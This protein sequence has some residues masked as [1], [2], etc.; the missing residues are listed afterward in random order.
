MSQANLNS[1]NTNSDTTGTNLAVLIVAANDALQ[2]CNKGASRPVYAQAGTPWID[3][4]AAEW[5]LNIFDGSND[6]SI[7]IIDVATGTIRTATSADGTSYIQALVNGEIV[8]SISGA[9]KS[10][11]D[12]TGLNVGSGAAPRAALDVRGTDAIIIPGGTTA[13]RPADVAGMVRLNSENNDIEASVGSGFEPL[14]LGYPYEIPIAD[15]NVTT[16]TAALIYDVPAGVFDVRF[17][18]EGFAGSDDGATLNFNVGNAGAGGVINDASIYGTTQIFI[19]AGSVQSGFQSGT[20]FFLTGPVTNANP[21]LRANGQLSLRGFRTPSSLVR[22]ELKCGY[23]NTA[24]DNAI[25]VCSFRT[26]VADNWNAIRLTASGSSN[27]SALT[28]RITGVIYG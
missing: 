9:L 14:R 10:R 8:T 12:A 18:F 28:G 2:S 19:N 1:T 13:E 20:S 5:V 15:I 25:V 27:I 23:A 21:L 24:L 6:I 16:D 4:S 3:D 17:D 26:N 22:G 11:I 7:G